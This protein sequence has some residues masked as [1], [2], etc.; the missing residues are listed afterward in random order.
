[1]GIIKCNFTEPDNCMDWLS[2]LV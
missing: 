1:M 2:S